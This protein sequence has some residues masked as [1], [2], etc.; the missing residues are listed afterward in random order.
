MKYCVFCMRAIK[1]DDLFCPHCGKKQEYSAPEYHLLPGTIVGGKYMLGAALG[2]GGFGITYIGIDVK[3][4]IRVAVKEYFPNGFVNRSG[5]ASDNVSISATQERAEFFQKGMVRFLDEARTL[6]KFSGEQGIVDVRDFFECNNTAYI[7]MEHLDGITLKDFIKKNGRL[8]AE[9][10]IRLLTPVMMSLEKVHGENLIHR[11]ISPDNI[12]VLKDRV[13]LLDFGAARSVSAESNKSLSVVLKPGYAPEEQYRSKGNQG[14]WTDVYAMSAT[15]YKCITGVTPDDATQRLYKDELKSPSSM[16][17]AI[18]PAAESA[19][20]KG[21]AVLQD[22][23]WQNM[24]QLI[25]GLQGKIYAPVPQSSEDDVKTVATV[26]VNNTVPSAPAREAVPARAA[27][28]M[29]EPVS[30]REAVPAPVG[31]PPYSNGG[32]NPYAPLTVPKKK[33]SNVLLIIFTL[34]SLVAAFVLPLGIFMHGYGIGIKA[35]AALAVCAFSVVPF[36]VSAIRGVKHRGVKK[37]TVAALC[38]L[39]AVIVAAVSSVMVFVVPYARYMGEWQCR[40]DDE[41]LYVY[42]YS[43]S[44]YQVYD[45]FDELRGEG[46][47]WVETDGDLYIDFDVDDVWDLSCGAYFAPEG[48]ELAFYENDSLLYR[49]YR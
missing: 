23:R 14:A 42:F 39:L 41:T 44:T 37:G 32:M 27:V 21:L 16:G 30:A 43:D 46:D 10:A 6:A 7:V 48:D 1:E 2:E 28:P 31:N 4:E 8:N 34:L 18:S 19:L 36:V 5:T 13:K 15:I 47:C 33:K 17:I 12:M 38:I 35:L 49:F 11:D 3:L 40:S 25:D 29:R 22:N 9:E 24:Q 26:A 20:L 45:A